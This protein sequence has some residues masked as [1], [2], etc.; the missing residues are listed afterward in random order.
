MDSDEEVA[1]AAMIIA[2]C[3]ENDE[4]KK[5]RKRRKVWVKPWLQ[6]RKVHVFY[7]QLLNELRLEDFEMYKNYLRMKP[8][9]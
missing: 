4:R 3:V 1:A 6:K 2:I 7:S 8:E 9:R 5:T